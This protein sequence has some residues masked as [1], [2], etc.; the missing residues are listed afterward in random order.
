VVG[1]TLTLELRDK[2][3][4]DRVSQDFGNRL[5]CLLLSLSA[6]HQYRSRGGIRRCREQRHE[7]VNV[8]TRA[9]L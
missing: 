4:V 7:A 3:F 9:A 5:A 1:E 2:F 8:A 6:E